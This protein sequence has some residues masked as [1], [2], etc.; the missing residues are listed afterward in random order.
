MCSENIIQYAQKINNPL[1]SKL[2]KFIE[3]FFHL[4]EIDIFCFKCYSSHLNPCF[5]HINKRCTVEDISYNIV[6]IERKYLDKAIVKM[7]DYDYCKYFFCLKIVNLQF[8]LFIFL[9]KIFYCFNNHE[10]YCHPDLI[11]SHSICQKPDFES[12]INKTA[13]QFY[14]CF[15]SA[16]FYCLCFKFKRCLKF[17]LKGF[18]NSEN[19]LIS[20]LNEANKALIQILEKND[21][22]K[23]KLCR[24]SI[25]ELDSFREM[26][27]FS[28][29]MKES[30]Y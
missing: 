2:E 21:S 12:I 17:L 24:M 6:R 16:S 30:S 22:N 23:C 26:K 9:G 13:I 5:C 25:Y 11:L 15:A 19:D 3:G 7:F 10:I 8:L 1:A 27:F 4:K 14:D 18:F 29:L 20:Q 28:D